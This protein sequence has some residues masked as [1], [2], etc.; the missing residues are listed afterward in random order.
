M[1]HLLNLEAIEGVLL[2]V[3]PV[4]RRLEERDPEFVPAAKAWLGEAERALSDNRLPA[5]S[6]VAAYLGELISVER[7]LPGG[8]AAGGALHRRRRTAAQ[9]TASLR[10][11]TEVVSQAIAPR[12]A[13]VDEGERVMMQLLALAKR[14]GLVP[15]EAGQTHTAW[16][17]S[18]LQAMSDRPELAALATHVIGLLGA[19]D[20][21]IVLDR[22]L[23]L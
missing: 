9:A 7:G 3:P 14:L 2:R 13:Q 12:R 22:C 17:E 10:S 11:A 20:A 16:L 21:L 18:I 23:S 4:V 15:A 6:R 5:A 1:L 8:P 19:A